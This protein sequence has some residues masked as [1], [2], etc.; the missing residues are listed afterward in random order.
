M[1]KLLIFFIALCIGLLIF[2]GIS[3]VDDLIRGA[4]TNESSN[5]GA[6][7][8]KSEGGSYSSIDISA[9]NAV[10]LDSDS[11][12]V[13][14]EKASEERCYPASTTKILTALVAIE[15]GDMNDIVTVGDEANFPLPGSSKAGILYG[16]K[17]TLNDLLKC[18]LIPSGNDAAYVIAVH[19]A[20]RMSENADMPARE[21]VSYFCRMMNKRAKEAGARHSNFANPD[22]YQCDEHYTTAQDMAL[23]AEQAMKYKVF[24]EIVKTEEFRLP[25][26]IQYNN[27]GE[28]KRIVRIL[29]NTNQLIRE[30]SEYRYRYA[31]G[32]KTGHTE[33]AGY[34]LVSTASYK[35]RNILSVAMNST[36][37]GI[38]LDSKE[39]LEYGISN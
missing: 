6:L 30:D 31:T 38:W 36:E 21:A 15:S 35:G 22:G 8:D 11:G 26:A 25:D 2:S 32:L 13:L 28:E 14:Y 24:R 9:L 1:K 37:K 5:T 20:R 29:R 4:D 12:K 7:R 39:L 33:E 17:Y 34:C 3:K 27:K 10:L 16:E 18:M 19:T 23:I